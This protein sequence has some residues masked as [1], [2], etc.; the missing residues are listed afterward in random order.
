MLL[1]DNVSLEQEHSF[2]VEDIPSHEIY[3]S[4]LGIKRKPLCKPDV[5]PRPTSV[6]AGTAIIKSD[7]CQ[8][9]PVFKTA[10]GQTYAKS[11]E[12][13][14]SS[15]LLLLGPSNKGFKL[16][17]KMGWR[18]RDGGL[19]KHRQGSLLPIKTVFQPGKKLGLGARNR[20]AARISHQPVNKE[21]VVCDRKMTKAERRKR[22]RLEHEKEVHD[23]RRIRMMLRTDISDE[24]EK[25][26][27]RLH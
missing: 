5:S 1:Q 22:Q 24:H 12:I 23:M 9:V 27:E 18:E 15:S 7:D 2:L 17:L 19:G 3:S 26:H 16:L 6:T 14:L 25:L 8:N 11:Q 20:K 4:L 13:Q 10:F 21:R